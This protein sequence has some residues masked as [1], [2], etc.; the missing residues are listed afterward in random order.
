MECIEII[1]AQQAKSIYA[2]RNAKQELI[3]K[4]TTIWFNKKCQMNHLIPKY[5]NIAING[6]NNKNSNP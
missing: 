1:N 6:K 5:M 4:N 2:Y 3:R